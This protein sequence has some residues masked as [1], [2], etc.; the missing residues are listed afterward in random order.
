M[1]INRLVAGLAATTMCV[2][3]LTGC[4]HSEQSGSSA[5]TSSSGSSRQGCIKDFDPSKDY[6]GDKATFGDA[7]DITVS[8][9]K[10][11]KIVTLKHPSNTATKPVQY[12]LVQCGAPD[13]HLD[14]ELAKAQRITIPTT[15]VALGS[16]TLPMKFQMLGKL[17]SVAGMV[18]VDRVGNPDTRQA[19]KDHK[20][21]SFAAGDN[22][23]EIDKIKEIGIPVVAEPNFLESTPL[24]RAEWIKYDSL[25]VNAEKTANQKYDEIAEKYHATAKRTA[26]VKTRPT[27]LH[28][29]QYKGVWY[30]KPNENYAIQFLRDAGGEYV[31]KDLHGVASRKLDTEAVIK[32]AHDADFWIDGPEKSSIPQILKADP[33]LKSLKALDNGNVW[34]ATLRADPKHGNDY[35]QTGVVRPDLVLA[36]LTAILHPEL[37]RDHQFHFYRKA[38]AK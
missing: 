26:K 5:N 24:G 37:D 2:A 34:D 30:I 15:K 9:H 28:G 6:F 8:Y 29:S 23:T 22:A 7:R 33:R 36:D 3:T 21:A 12:V 32:Q 35:W 14:G 27:V 1:S 4:S 10:S 18:N 17:D 31:F 25:F 19:L 38:T 13:P 11:Y 16:T 20:V